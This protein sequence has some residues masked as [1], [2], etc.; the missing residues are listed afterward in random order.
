MATDRALLLALL[1]AGP[2][3]AADD[4]EIQR[5]SE[6]N[7][8]K[9]LFARFKGIADTQAR[10]AGYS[11]SDLASAK[12]NLGVMYQHGLGVPRN[13]AKALLW[14]EKAALAGQV[15][16]QFNLGLMYYQGQGTA[17]DFK[18]ARYWLEKAAQQGY[19][20]AAYQLGEM[21][22]HEDNENAIQTK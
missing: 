10:N 20:D 1:L 6:E 14:Y 9:E 13:D 8:Y 4:A 7:N 19:A 3:F 22:H 21:S 16:A 18:Q 2:A 17:Q 5:L 15:K 12:Y 11:L